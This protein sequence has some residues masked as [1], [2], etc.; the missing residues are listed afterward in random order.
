MI[1]GVAWGVCWAVR[2]RRQPRPSPG[3]CCEGWLHS[4]WLGGVRLPAQLPW[5]FGVSC[6]TGGISTWALMETRCQ[7]LWL[8]RLWCRAQC[9]RG[10]RTK[11]QGGPPHSLGCLSPLPPLSGGPRLP[12]PAARPTLPRLPGS[13]HGKPLE[14]RRLGGE[15]PPGG[16]TWQG[17]TWGC[18][19]RE[20]W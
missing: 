15:K 19:G 10:C 18:G 20:L 1:C 6:E 12:G 3:C 16:S 8:L 4:S 5:F 11:G 2:V 9:R 13:G 7:R 14:G 17:D